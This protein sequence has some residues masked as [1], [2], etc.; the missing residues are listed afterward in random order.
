M[1]YRLQ[2][3][4]PVDIANG[5]VTRIFWGS[6]PSAGGAEITTTRDI[7]AFAG[8]RSY[9]V[10]LASL[11][12]GA[13]GGL[14]SHGAAEVWTTNNKRQFRFDPH[15]FAA[16]RQFHLDDVKLT[17]IPESSGTYTIRW[18]GADADGDAATVNL[19]L[20]NDRNPGNGKTTILTGLPIAQASYVWNSSGRAAGHLLHLRGSVRRRQHRRHLFGIADHPRHRAVRV[21]AR[22]GGRVRAVCRQR[23]HGRRHRQRV[24]L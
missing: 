16:A 15:E 18:A 8:M 1:T 22:A 21:H 24:H 12:V 11:S 10:D 14:E 13:T 2:V 9:T 7:V 20:D 19:Y 6:G 5:S 4:G 3:D 17:A 23:R